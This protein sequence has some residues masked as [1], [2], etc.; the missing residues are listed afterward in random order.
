MGFAVILN[1]NQ[2]GTD[3][4]QI[5]YTDNDNY[6]DE[7]GLY[8]HDAHIINLEV[9][10]DQAYISR[11]PDANEMID[12]QVQT[13]QEKFLDE[14]GMI[15]D[16]YSPMSF[17]S[18]ADQMCSSNPNEP[19]AHGD[20]SLCR[21]SSVSP[22]NSSLENLHH[23]N[24]YNILARIELPNTGETMKIAYIGHRMCKV[25]GESHEGNTY[26][27][28]SYSYLGFAAVMNFDS[29]K[30]STKTLIHE[31]GH[32]F[33]APD[34]YDIGDVPSTGELNA[35]TEG[36]AYSSNCIYGE[37]KENADVLDNLTICDGC[38]AEIQKNIDR[39]NH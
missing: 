17:S 4:T 11:Y 19:C 26:L 22:N 6:R 5:S 23:K 38:R 35:E 12:N 7:W 18:Y 24:L 20:D 8:E 27:G 36:S 25:D 30:S 33:G 37:N 15:I 10:Y 28:L 21:N 39:Y 29:E 13:L 1:E 9:I 3:L 16:F 34:H 2:N 32:F 14:F 31:F